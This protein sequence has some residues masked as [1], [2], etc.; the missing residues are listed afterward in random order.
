MRL[1]VLLISAVGAVVIKERKIYGICHDPLIYPEVVGPGLARVMIRSI[2]RRFSSLRWETLRVAARL[3]KDRMRRYLRL[4]K[5]THSAISKSLYGFLLD[6]NQ[7]PE[8]TM[9]GVNTLW[10][11]FR[12]I[13]PDTSDSCTSMLMWYLSGFISRVGREDPV[14]TEDVEVVDG[15]VR[16][17]SDAW[18]NK[19]VTTH[20]FITSKA[21]DDEAH[22]ILFTTDPAPV[23]RSDSRT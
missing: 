19:I 14:R 20:I 2:P 10:N 3:S 5:R 21:D 8:G 15:E 11:R 6:Y 18:A 7:S 1:F 17:V 13:N 4:V 12:A 9:E 22:R 16:I 23:V